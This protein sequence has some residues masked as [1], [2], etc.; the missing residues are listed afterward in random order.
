M[1]IGYS[2]SHV[3]AE[4]APAPPN[5]A[6][7]WRRVERAEPVHEAAFPA[8]P[9]ALQVAAAISPPTSRMMIAATRCYHPGGAAVTR[10]VADIPQT[11]NQRPGA[12]A[13]ADLSPRRMRL[14]GR[15]PRV[16]TPT[17]TRDRL[18]LSS[19]DRGATR[20]VDAAVPGRC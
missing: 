20:T 8:A 10:F 15:R 19:S 3:V 9:A 2:N 5:A 17:W 14:R 6:L 7:Y 16:S 4:R 13:F 11:L 18:D 1:Q 12:G